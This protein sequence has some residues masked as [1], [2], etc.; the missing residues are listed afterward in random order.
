[1]EATQ[2]PPRFHAHLE[3]RL[4]FGERKHG[5][6]HRKVA[7]GQF[8]TGAHGEGH[9]QSEKLGADL[10]GEAE[11]LE[12]IFSAYATAGSMAKTRPAASTPNPAWTAWTAR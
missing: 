10:G 5:G 2:A 12:Q 9:V 11:A 1:M 3:V 8:Q 7:S 6:V 4:T